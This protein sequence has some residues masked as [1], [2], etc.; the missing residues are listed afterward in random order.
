MSAKELT[1]IAVLASILYCI[2]FVGSFFMYVELVGFIVLLYGV[3]LDRKTSYFASLVF[4]CLV[5][6][7]RGLALWT[8]MYIIV[9]PQYA[10]IYHY[11]SKVT[12]SEYAYGVVGFIL[13]FMTGTIIE[14]PYI[15]MSGMAGKALITYLILGFQVSLGNA[16]CTLIATIF[17][18]KPLKKLL[19]KVNR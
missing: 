14:I 4:A 19:I 18:V 11:L 15:F 17:L 8:L 1:R 3:S 10:L 6:L 9:F 13:S 2:Y 5:V 12:K 7:T 16:A